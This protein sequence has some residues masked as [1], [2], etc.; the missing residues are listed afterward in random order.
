MLRKCSEEL[1]N[2][3]VN[4]DLDNININN[5]DDN[6]EKINSDSEVSDDNSNEERSSSIEDLNKKVRSLSI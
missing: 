4:S 2:K 1:W 5:V 6:D 3:I